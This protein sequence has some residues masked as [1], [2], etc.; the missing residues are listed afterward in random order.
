MK[1]YIFGFAALILGIYLVYFDTELLIKIFSF[2]RNLENLK[3][4]YF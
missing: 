3:F 4:N 1:T 2:L